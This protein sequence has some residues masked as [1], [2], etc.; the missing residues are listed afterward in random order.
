M[1]VAGFAA[2]GP[3]VEP[4]GEPRYIA[5]ASFL[6]AGTPC[7]V[8]GECGTCERCDA[9]TCAN[10]P[11]PACEHPTTPA[12][13]MY[14]GAPVKPGIQWKWKQLA[15]TPGFDPSTDTVGLCLWWGDIPIF[16][17]SVPPDTGWITKPTGTV[18]FRDKTRANAGIERIKVGRS[19][20]MVKAHG[21]KILENPHGFPDA[22]LQP[23]D[24]SIPLQVQLHAGDQCYATT[25]PQGWVTGH[26][27]SHVRRGKGF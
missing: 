23:A 13:I 24:P 25:S 21:A 1:T 22:L 19:G 2:D 17:S 3:Y 6:A 14:A 27:P 11:R 9:A 20:L 12:N 4:V 18:V 8:D 5:L 7:A 16:E 10:G 15:G 26:W